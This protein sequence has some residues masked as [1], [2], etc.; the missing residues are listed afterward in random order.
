MGLRTLALILALLSLLGIVSCS[1]GSS[2]A[3]ITAVTVSCTPTSLQSGQTSSCTASVTGT[4]TFVTTV[5][6]GSSA[7]SVD[8]NGV[9][10]AQA[11]TASTAVTVNATSTQDATQ[12]GSATLTVTPVTAISVS[13]SPTVIQPRQSSQCTALANGTSTT[14]VNWSSSIGTISV[15]GL[16]TAPQVTAA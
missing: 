1:G 13:C 15:S 2:T 14:Q 4:G 10:T 12:T 8:V 6:W 5:T 11:V 3:T 16:F 7:G 9:F